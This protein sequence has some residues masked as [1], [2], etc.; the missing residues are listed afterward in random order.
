LLALP[1]LSLAVHAQD[2]SVKASL[3]FPSQHPYLLVTP[4]DPEHPLSEKDVRLL[5][6]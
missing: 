5:V 2:V 4:V 3:K 1:T 6:E